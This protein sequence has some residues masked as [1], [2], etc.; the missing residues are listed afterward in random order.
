MS[1]APGTPVPSG[2]AAA[3]ARLGERLPAPPAP[4]GAYVPVRVAGDLLFTSGMLPMRDGAVAFTGRVGAELTVDQ[5]REAALLCARNAVAA[6][7][8]ALGGVEGLARVREVVQVT[9]HVLSAE[10]FSDQPAVVDRASTWLTEVFGEAGR[11][12]RLALGAFALPRN[13]AVELALVVRIGPA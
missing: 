5:A 7:A 2:P 1:S 6:L 11:H 8:A 4:L 12:T 13:A 9:G 10:G 3:L